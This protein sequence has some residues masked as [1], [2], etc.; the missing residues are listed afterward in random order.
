MTFAPS[1]DVLLAASWDSKLRLY[2]TSTSTL[3]HTFAHEAP[4]LDGCFTDNTHGVGVGLDSRVQLY[5]F[6]RPNHVTLLGQHDAGIRC[7]EYSRDASVVL[8]GGWD[9]VVNGWDTRAPGAAVASM[10]LPGKCFSM[11][12]G[13]NRLVVGTSERR[14]LCFDTRMLKALDP[15]KPEDSNTPPTFDRESFLRFQTRAVRCSPDGESFAVSSIEGRVAV[16]YFDS[17]AEGKKYAFKCHRMA[18]T[19]FPVNCIAF[20]PFYGTFATGGCDGFVAIWDGKNKKRLCQLPSFPTSIAALCF[21]HDGTKLAVAASYTFEEG[22]KDAPQDQIY[23]KAV[24]DSEVKP[25]ARS[26]VQ[27]E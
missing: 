17:D 16:D 4:V 3:V 26:L 5:D 24:H 21:N 11:S 7:A 12:M 2:D 13:E 27:G 1:T 14:I 10:R 22:E 8:T 18:N 19:V 9:K 20:H 15:S 25:K 6:N 23:V